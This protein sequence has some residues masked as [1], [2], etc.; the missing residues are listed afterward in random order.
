MCSQH[1]SSTAPNFVDDDNIRT[2]F[3]TAAAEA[4]DGVV[5]Y[6]SCMP[7]APTTHSQPAQIAA[8]VNTRYNTTLREFC[9]PAPA[10]PTTSTPPRTPP[11]PRR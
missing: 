5:L 10:P 9:S 4:I 8:L 3:A 11:R 1:F 6:G 7:R 2:P